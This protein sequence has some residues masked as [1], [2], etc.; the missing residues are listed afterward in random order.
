MEVPIRNGACQ[1]M[2]AHSPFHIMDADATNDPPI[3]PTITP[4]GKSL[5]Y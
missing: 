4:L 5:I 2:Q 1:N 3:R